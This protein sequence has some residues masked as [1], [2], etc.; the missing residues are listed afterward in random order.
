MAEVTLGPAIA[1]NTASGT[2]SDPGVPT[3]PTS[4]AF[5]CFHPTFQGVL[6]QEFLAHFD[7]LLD[8][9]GRRIVFG[10]AEPEGGSRTDLNLVDGRPAVD[11]DQGRL[12]L[13]SGT[14]TAI[15]FG[16]S[17]PASRATIQTASGARSVSAVRNFR[18]RIAGRAYTTA[19]VSVPKVSLQEDGLVPA[20]LFHAIYVCNSGKYLVI[21]PTPWSGR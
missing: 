6:G 19:A 12:V 2:A 1:S 13:D 5:I 17:S 7:Y 8:F 18:L 9:A 20:S 16:T 11:T 14:E 21:D 3:S 10:S 4:K 15:L